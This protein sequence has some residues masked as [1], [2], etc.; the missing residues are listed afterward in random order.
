M[1]NYVAVTIS[2]KQ[3]T[4]SLEIPFYCHAEESRFDRYRDQREETYYLCEKRNRGLT[5][6]LEKYPS[7]TH[8]LSLD[9]YYVNQAAALRELINAYE[10]IND[11]NIILGGPIWYYRLNRLFDNRPKFYDAWGSP[12]LLNIH[13]KD[14]DGFPQIVQV[15][16]VGNCVIFPVW[17]WK[18]Y[19]FLTPEPFPHMG[20]CYTRLCKMS[21]L[22][23]L[24]DMKA[25]LVR[26]RTNS[27]EAYYPLVKRFRVST[28]EYKN[29]V[30]RKLRLQPA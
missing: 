17:V 23:V 26:D 24:I 21:G 25:R 11:D 12:E 7:S 3:E 10:E 15:P 19:G 30:L 5:K 1:R 14:T 27:S 18:K 20:S 8:V 28:G 13:P 29:R 4:F 22:P 9:S 16:S 2:R 6:A